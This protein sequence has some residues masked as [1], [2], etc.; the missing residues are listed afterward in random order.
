MNITD[1]VQS[2]ASWQKF[3]QHKH[4]SAKILPSGLLLGGVGVAFVSILFIS[5]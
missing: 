5:S 2:K 1:Q 4:A 3:I